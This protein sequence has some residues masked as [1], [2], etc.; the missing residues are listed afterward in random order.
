MN[1]VTESLLK[2]IDDEGLKNFVHQWDQFEQLIIEINRQ[3]SLS[4]AQQEDFFELQSKLTASY[5]TWESEMELYWRQTRIKE[6]NLMEDPFRL[7]LD[8]ESARDVLGNWEAMKLLPAAR[9][10]MNLM[11]MDKRGGK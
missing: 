4:F 6:G 7:L 8:S 1:P 10:A 9:E 5:V 2:D 11:L 3:K